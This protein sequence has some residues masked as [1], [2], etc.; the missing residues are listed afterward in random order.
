MNALLT[1]Q[2]ILEL[3][4]M[5]RLVCSPVTAL[6]FDLAEAIAAYYGIPPFMHHLRKKIG[7]R[8]KVSSTQET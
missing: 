2:G 4:A 7:Q 8:S 1:G 5:P 6:L 3:K